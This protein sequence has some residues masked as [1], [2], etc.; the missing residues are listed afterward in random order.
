MTVT[1]QDEGASQIV[2]STVLNNIKKP[3]YMDFKCL[4]L[5]L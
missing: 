2:Q 3:L 4:G 1:N 5:L